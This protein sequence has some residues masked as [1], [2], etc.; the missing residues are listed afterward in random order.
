MILNKSIRDTRRVRQHGN[1]SELN[2][3]FLSVKKSFGCTYRVELRTGTLI[4]CSA[5]AYNNGRSRIVFL[6]ED[7]IELLD[8]EGL[9]FLVGHEMGHILMIENIFGRSNKTAGDRPVPAWRAPSVPK[10]LRILISEFYSETMADAFGVSACGNADIP[11]KLTDWDYP[12]MNFPERFKKDGFERPSSDFGSGYFTE[13][14]LKGLK[15]LTQSETYIYGIIGMPLFHYQEKLLADSE[16]DD[17]NR[18]LLAPIM[19]YSHEDNAALAEFTGAAIYVA[20]PSRARIASKMKFDDTFFSFGAFSEGNYAL[21]SY[22]SVDDALRKI[23]SLKSK[24]HDINHQLKYAA[25][26]LISKAA[27]GEDDDA[28]QSEAFLHDIGNDMGIDFFEIRESVERR[29]YCY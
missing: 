22:S 29:R 21:A 20:N 11:L 1:N 5:Q 15:L 3:L 25:F 13:L 26:S 10:I 27:F 8:E 7:Y 23:V 14:K 24:V 9:L 12:D 28:V 18:E 2:Q 6:D 19:N 17:R 4:G 16:L